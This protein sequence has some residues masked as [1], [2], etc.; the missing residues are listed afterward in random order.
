MD[1]PLGEVV[2]VVPAGGGDAPGAPEASPESSWFDAPPAPSPSFRDLALAAYREAET[3][4]DPEWAHAMPEERA[5]AV[6]GRILTVAREAQALEDRGYAGPGAMAAYLA[7]M[8]AVAPEPIPDRH[9]AVDMTTEPEVPDL[10]DLAGAAGLVAPPD[11]DAWCVVGLIR[12]GKLV[13]L[14]SGEGVGK[15]S[16]RKE[17]ELRLAT[18]HG[19]LFGHYPIAGPVRVGTIDEENGADEEWRREEDLL[20]RLGIVRADLAGRYFRGSFLG[21]DLNAPRSQAYIR[22]QVATFALEVLFLDT[23]GSM[24]DEEYG[25]PLKGAVRF[26]R[27]LIREVPALAIVVCVHMVKPPRGPNV[28]APKRRALTDVMG[29]WTRQADVVAVMT[30]LGNDR[31]RWELAKR[32]G[33]PK[34]VGILDYSDGLTHWVADADEAV[35]PASVGDTIRTLRCIAAGADSWEQ[36]KEATGLGR[37]KVFA[38]ISELRGGGLIGPG[39]PYRLTPDGQ[40]ALE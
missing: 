24:V 11:I 7:D 10:P 17:M 39:T 5:A 8:L 16:V 2:D 19:S 29:Q 27:S 13:Y 38:A 12:P 23:G 22:R 40:D 20:P 36:V 1:P 35:D 9:A 26:L 28:A 14:A 6:A 15:S 30:D 21:L 3:N 18:G 32:R 37:N 4:G 25:P 31:V 33:V 34:S